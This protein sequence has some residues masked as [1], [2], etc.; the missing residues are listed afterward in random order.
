MTARMAVKLA[1]LLAGCSKKESKFFF[2]QNLNSFLKTDSKHNS[3]NF[4]SGTTSP[5]GFPVWKSSGNSQFGTTLEPKSIHPE[6]QT[7]GWFWFGWYQFENFQKILKFVRGQRI[8]NRFR[9]CPHPD[10]APKS[11]NRMLKC[12]NSSSEIVTFDDTRIFDTVV[13]WSTF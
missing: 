10:L 6:P 3:E 11:K 4:Q 12:H 13:T 1:D 7:M 2:G 9:N 8:A 5:E